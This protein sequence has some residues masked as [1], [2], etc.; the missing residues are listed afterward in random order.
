MVR[1]SSP[2]ALLALPF[3]CWAACEFDSWGL[4]L[5]HPEDRGGGQLD[6]QGPPDIGTDQDHRSPVDLSEDLLMPELG[7]DAPHD[8]ETP[9]DVLADAPALDSSGHDAVV[10]PDITSP[11]DNTVSPAPDTSLQ[12]CQTLFGAI[13]K[14]HLCDEKWD[15]CKFFREGKKESC[16]TFC[17]THKC[18]DANAAD[19]GKQC[20]TDTTKCNSKQTD[21]NCTC[22]KF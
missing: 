2:Y 20:N 5:Y 7:S 8:A 16:D 19:S 15:R 4:P 1:H 6:R 14:Y 22:S 17:G 10:L 11:Q 9:H 12:S 21:S 18:L 13:K 3:L